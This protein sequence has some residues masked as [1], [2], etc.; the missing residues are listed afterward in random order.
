MDRPAGGD[1]GTGRTRWRATSGSV[2]DAD[3]D[4]DRVAVI[5]A[6]LEVP[7][8]HLH[9]IPIRSE[10]DIDFAKADHAATSDGAR[11]RRRAHPDGAPGRRLATA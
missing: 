5:V 3:F 6:G 4:C 9:L 7:H 1:L 11:R 8:C 10:S 2:L